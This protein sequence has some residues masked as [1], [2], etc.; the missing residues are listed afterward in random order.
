MQIVDF[1][2]WQLFRQR[3]RSTT[4][5]QHLLCQGFRKDVNLQSVNRDGTPISAVPGWVSTHPNSHVTALKASPWPQ[6]HALMGKEGHKVMIDLILDCGI[7]V[8]VETG[9]GNYYQLSGKPL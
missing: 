5:S 2:I 4:R 7:F 3:S 8:A 9:I 6:V 1:A